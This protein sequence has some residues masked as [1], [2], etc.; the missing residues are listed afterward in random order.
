MTTKNPLQQFFRRA[1]FSIYLPSRGKWYPKSAITHQNGQIDI[2]AMTATDESRM[3]ASEFLINGSAVF[4]IIRSCAPSIT[5]PEYMPQV[6]LEAVMLSIRRA[7][8][9]DTI[10]LTTLVPNTS[11]SM[12]L[13]LNIE[14]LVNQLPNAET[15]WDSTLNIINPD[16]HTLSL[17]IKPISLKS[18]FSVTRQIIR[19]QQVTVDI[20]KNN[21]AGDEKIDQLD[22]QMKTLA[23]IT[24]N[25]VAESISQIKFEGF[26]TENPAEIKN[27]IN[28]ID[29]DY[30]KAIQQH[31]ETQKEKINFAP[32]T[33][34]ATDEQIK[35]G[36]PESWVVPVQ[37][38]L[39]NFFEI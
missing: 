16:S 19:Q 6:D 5:Q 18:M 35:Q 9:G 20:S 37:F 11:E 12:E 33:V 14:Q 21:Q 17:I 22:E 31:I 34:K 24:V 38:D 26:S 8:F 30:F 3:R 10:K 25:M 32:I 28:N 15:E 1:K 13:D 36:A 23:D 39:T 27:F 2:F 7:T 29:L 4:D